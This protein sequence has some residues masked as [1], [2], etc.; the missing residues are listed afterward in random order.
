[1]SGPRH[2]E[3]FKIQVAKQ[4]TKRVCPVPEAAK[5]HIISNHSFY[6]WLNSSSM[7]HSRSSTILSSY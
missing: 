2:S 4:V 5:A 3:T 1:M 6:I 7:I